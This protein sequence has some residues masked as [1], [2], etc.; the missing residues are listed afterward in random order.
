MAG[1][2]TR[3]PDVTNGDLSS[4]GTMFL[5]TVIPAWPKAVSACLPV[6]FFERKSINIQWLSVPPEMTP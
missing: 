3:I 2:P 4:K 6:M 1:V 5:F